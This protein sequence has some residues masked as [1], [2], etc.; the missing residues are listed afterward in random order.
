MKKVLL[1]I[2]IKDKYEVDSV[3][4]VSED[5]INISLKKREPR[6]M[7]FEEIV[8]AKGIETGQFYTDNYLARLPVKWQLEP[9]EIVNC[10]N[11]TIWKLIPENE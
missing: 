3:W 9:T 10:T 1:E 4:S 5:S 2:E 11:S 7:I 6:R 8:G